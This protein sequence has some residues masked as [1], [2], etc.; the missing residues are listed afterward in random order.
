M[1]QMGRLWFAI[2]TMTFALTAAGQEPPL[3][4]VNAGPRGALSRIE[5]ANEIRVVFSEPMV[6]LGRIPDQ[7][8]A[9]FFQISPRVKGSFRWSGTTILIFTPDPQSPLAFAT[10]YTVTIEAGA[11]SASGRKLVAAQ[12]FQFTT[13]TVRLLRTDSYRRGGTVEQPILLLLRF[14][15]PVRAQD[16]VAHLTAV[17]ERHDWNPPSFS[18]EEMNRLR[19]V[20]S[21]LNAF[22]SKVD[23]TRRIAAG[24]A[25]VPLRLTNDWDKERYTPSADLVVVETTNAVPP[26]SWIRLQLDEKLPS[27]AGPETPEGDQTFTVKAEPAFF[28]EGFRCSNA[29]DADGWNPLRIRGEVNVANFSAAVNATDITSGEQPLRR[30]GEPRESFYNAYEQSTFLTLEDAG[31][32]A[33]PPDRKYLVALPATFKAADG[34]TLGYPWIGIVENWHKRA[35]SSFGD[36]HGVWEKDGGPELPFF[37]RN[38][39]NVRQWTTAIKPAELMPRLL[40]LNEN[41]FSLAPPGEGTVRQLGL[42]A[43]RVQSH[44]LNLS[45][46]LGSSGTGLVWA[47]VRDGDLLPRTRRYT[48]EAPT[49]GAMIQVTNL[50]ISVKDSPQNVLVI[51]TRLDTGEPVAGAKVSIVR[52]DNSTAWQGSTGADGIVLAPTPTLRDPDNYWKFSFIVIAEKDNDVAY[53]GSD[54]NEGI[55]PW[56]FDTDVNLREREPLLR[57][58]VFTDRGVYRLGEEVH[59]KALLRHNTPS[60]VQ[61][62]PEGTAVAIT[63]H[64]TQSRVVD[65]RVVRL[66][67]WSSAEW[68]M[69]LPADGVLGGYSVRAILDSD[70]ARQADSAREKLLAEAPWLRDIEARE[71]TVNASFLVAAYRRP[72]FRVDVTLTS[73]N[74]IAGRPLRGLISARYLFGASMGIRPV[75]WRFTRQAGRDAPQAILEKFNRDR[76]VFVGSVDEQ[77]YTDSS[78]IRRDETTLGSSGDLPVS[79]QASADAGVPYVYSLEGDVEDVTRQHIANRASLTVHPAPW[80]I[81]VRRA[82]YFLE[83]RAGLNTELIAAGLDGVLVS[84]VPVEV[85]LT[86][87]QWNSVRRAEGNGFYTWETEKREVPAGKWNIVSGTDPV[88]LQV[89]FANEGYY[90]LEAR[91]TGDSGEFAVTKT[92]FY[93]LGEGYTAWQR[94]DHNRIDLVP[95]RQTYKPGETARIMIQSPWEQATAVVTKEREGIRSY[96]RFALVSTQQSVSVPITPEDIPN[97][98]V[99]VLLVKGR[100]NAAPSNASVEDPE[101]DISDPGKPSFRLGYLELKVEDQS[102]RLRV[103]L[104]TDRTEYRPAAKAKLTLNVRDSDGKGAQGEVTLWAV[105]YGV[106]SLTKYSPPDI[107]Q[108][109]YVRKALQV[110]NVDSRQRI[111]ERRVLTPKGET[112][113]GGGGVDAGAGTLRKDFRVLAFWLGSIATGPDGQASVDVTLPES[114]TTYRIMAVV[115]DRDSRFGSADTDVRTSKPVTLRPAFPRFLAVGD[116]ALFGAVVTNQLQR[117][118]TAVV[119]MKSLDPRI[120][121]VSGASSQRTTVRPGESLEIRF[122]GAARAVGRA[123]IQMAARIDNDSDAF[124]ELLPVELLVSPETVAAYGEVTD[125]SR[126]ATESLVVPKGVMPGFGDLSAELASTAMVGLGESAQYLVDYPY[127]CAEQKASASLGLILSSDIGAAFALQGMNTSQ[128]RTVAQSTLKELEKFQCSNGGF[129][130]WP[131]ACWSTSPYLTSYILHVF[132]TAA[133]LGYTVNSNGRERAYNYLEKELSASPPDV[134]EGWWPSYTAWQAFAVKVLVEGGRNQDSNLTRLYGYRDRMPIFALAYLHDAMI[135]RSEKTGDR[136]ADLRRRMTNAIL[137]EGGSAHV[138]ELSDQYLLWFWNSNVRSTAI[139]LNSLVNGDVSAAPMREIV[140][141]LMSARKDGRWGN[142]QENAHALQA[143]VAFY[144]KHEATVPDFRGSAVL[145]KRELLRKQFRGRSTEAQTKTLPMVQL[146]DVAPA[147]TSVPLT[148]RRDGRGTMYYVSRLRYVTDEVQPQELDSGFRIQREYAPYVEKGNR[149]ASLDYSAGDLVRVTLKLHLTK[150]RRFVAVTDPL[151]AGFEPVESWFATTARDLAYDQNRQSDA[152]TEV[153]D[154]RRWWNRGGFDRVES[155]DDRIQL[156]ATRLSE[157][158]HEFSYI[159]RATTAGTFR[160]APARAEEMYQPEVFGRT[161]TH[162]V[163]IKQ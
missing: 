18:P 104:K 21:A 147:G 117:G 156:F 1:A 8:T 118:G 115:S 38:L 40:E 95:E 67:T 49:R 126:S 27:P 78:D 53:V 125:A 112:D 109:V 130:Y 162:G 89:P 83:Q 30:A 87:V 5:Q 138:E 160:T 82:P 153:A 70:R 11:A 72:E 46:A 157:G 94:Y 17:T 44:G 26:E 13:P 91:G 151:P 19:A 69:T 41:N 22:N 135:A 63:V 93:V 58:S 64:D 114:L 51:V 74:P 81:G 113:G 140:R 4:I 145:G 161:P 116:T 150:E 62:L 102:K 56:N 37:A 105:D 9:P 7:V 12:S 42:V 35:F 10:K 96:E 100:S 59:F 127:G 149:P 48:D 155:H 2:L 61:L 6:P 76:W 148:F 103:N 154:W 31:F 107:A 25:P 73:E 133:D 71:K 120:F 139:V 24:G 128:M 129:G 15:Q 152:D 108:S 45:R 111:I 121:A 39:R 142:T 77:P 98:F 110:F 131:G 158:I 33:Q 146:L 47:A 34:Q 14:N 66:N 90:I 137:P 20:P 32:A 99:S 50:G 159:V 36:R 68:T 16:V 55:S 141:W 92:D 134:N 85:T 88:T 65:E 144:K 106:L 97:V 23:T 54:W 3:K 86:Q 163:R 79:L 80:Y 29:C 57:G 119:S 43:D 52:V 75:T 28:V 60:G 124:E 101:A 84:G 122:T 132:K 136:I 123:R 143:L